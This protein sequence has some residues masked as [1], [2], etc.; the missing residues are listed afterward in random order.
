MWNLAI[1][2]L[3]LVMPAAAFLPHMMGAT[4]RADAR[5]VQRLAPKGRRAVKQSW[6]V[7]MVNCGKCGVGVEPSASAMFDTSV[8]STKAPVVA[9]GEKK[10]KKREG[11]CCPCCPAD[12]SCCETE[13]KCNA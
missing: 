12:C 1:L 7:A 5:P 3:A 9:K 4:A 8:V 13:C 11:G 10:H 2:L 6:D